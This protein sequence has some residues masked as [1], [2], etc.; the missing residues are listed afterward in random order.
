MGQ[1]SIF[2]RMSP[3]RAAYL[4]SR[5]FTVAPSTT[6]AQLPARVINTLYLPAVTSQGQLGVCGAY[7]I[8]YYYKTYQEAREHGWEHPNPSVDPEH[9]AS[10]AYTYKLLRH[11]PQAGANPLEVAQ[12]MVDFG[13]CDWQTMPY[14]DTISTVTWPEE[15]YW[16]AALPWRA[17]AAGLIEDLH[18]SQGLQTLKA[19]LAA[20]DLACIALDASPNLFGYPGKDYTSN[21]VLYALDAQPGDDFHAL[22]VIGYDDGRTYLNDITGEECHGAFLT[23]NSWGTNW[24]V[25]EPTMGTGGF[26]WIAYDLFKD[27]ANAIP[28]AYVMQ[29][30]TDYT[31]K[32]A[33]QLG[34]NNAESKLFG[35]LT[36]SGRGDHVVDLFPGLGMEARPTDQ[37]IWIDVS[38]LAA[39]G[40]AGFRLNIKDFSETVRGTFPVLR[41]ENWAGTHGIDS[42]FVP[43]ESPCFLQSTPQA[44]E[45]YCGRYQQALALSGATMREGDSAWGDADGDG[46]PDLVLTGWFGTTLGWRTLYFDNQGASGFVAGDKGLPAG[47]VARWVDADGDGDL[48]LLI[49]DDAGTSL[50]LNN[51]AAGFASSG[52]PLPGCDP[53]CLAVADFDNDG[54]ADLC[55]GNQEETVLYMNDGTGGFARL[56]VGLPTLR[57]PFSALRGSQIMAADLNGDHWT[58][59]VIAGIGEDATGAIYLNQGLPLRFTPSPTILPAVDMPAVAIADQDGDG[60]LDLAMGGC[61]GTRQMRIFCNDGNGVFTDQEDTILPNLHNGVICWT[62]LNGDGRPDLVATGRESDVYGAHDDY[63]YTNDSVA[64]T[65]TA[66]GTYEFFGPPLAKVS[67]GVAGIADADGDGNPDILVGGTLAEIFESDTTKMTAAVYLHGA[68]FPGWYAGNSFPAAPTSLSAAHDGHG[69]VTFTWNDASDAETT[70]AA[71]RYI[72]RCGTTSGGDEIR[73]G[74]VSLDNAGLFCQSGLSLGH[75]PMGTLHWQVRSID[76]AD[77]LSPWS[78]VQTFAVPGYTPQYQLRI[79]PPAN[80]YAGTTTPAPGVYTYLDGQSA[81]VTASPSPGFEFVAW[82]GDTSGVPDTGTVAVPMTGHRI[83]HPLFSPVPDPANPAWTRQSE[84]IATNAE[85]IE[86][87][88]ESFDGY[89]LRLGGRVG[90]TPRNLVY[91]STDGQSWQQLWEL[92]WNQGNTEFND[93]PWSGRYG[94]CSAVF[95]GKLWIMGGDTNDGLQSDV[96]SASDLFHWTQTTASAPWEARLEAGCAVFDGKLWILGGDSMSGYLDDVWATADGVTWTQVTSDAPWPPGPVQATVFKNQ[97]TVLS[98]GQVWQSANG[99]DWQLLTDSAPFGERVEASLEVYNGQLTVCGGRD[100]VWGAATNEVWSSDDGLTWTKTAPGEAAHWSAR[101]YPATCIHDGD[102]WLVGGRDDDGDAL[103]DVWSLGAEDLP[104]NLGRLRLSATPLDGGTLSPPASGAYIDGIGT[105]FELVATPADGY[106]FDHWDGPVAD[107]NS[108]ATTVTL[109]RDTIVTAHF[110]SSTEPLTMIMTPSGAGSV[111]PGTSVHTRGV[112]V[113]LLAT[114]AFGYV[115]DH[116]EGDA[117]GTSRT[118]QVLM[119]QARTTTAVFVVDPALPR[120]TICCSD[121]WATVLKRDGTVWAIGHNGQAQQGH[122]MPGYTDTFWP[123]AMASGVREAAIDEHGGIAV[124]AQGTLLGWGGYWRTTDNRLSSHAVYTYLPNGIRGLSGMRT[125]YFFDRYGALFDGLNRP[126]EV[127]YNGEG[128]ANVVSLAE[129]PDSAFAV[130]RNGELYAWGSNTCGQLGTGIDLASHQYPQLVLGIA[131]V[132]RIACGPEEMASFTLALCDDGSVW[133]WGDNTTGQLGRTGQADVPGAVPG[134]EQVV[135]VVAGAHYGMALDRNGDL[136]GWGSNNTGHFG[137]GDYED[138]PTPQR[139]ATGIAD[140]GAGP[141]YAVA[142]R[143]DGSFAWCGQVPGAASPLLAW[144]TIPGMVYDDPSIPLSVSVDPVEATGFYPAVGTHAIAPG[145]AVP[146]QAKDSTRYTFA[147]W[148]DVAADPLA[149]ETTL[150][151]TGP[152]TLAVRYG[153]A[154]DAMAK[155]TVGTS[156]GGSAS[157]AAG[158]WEY[159]PGT[160][161]TLRA[162]PDTSHRFRYWDGAVSDARSRDTTIVLDRDRTVLAHF[163]AIPLDIPPQVA[164]GRINAMEYDALVLHSDTHVQD[165]G[166]TTWGSTIR[167]NGESD[168]LDDVIRVAVGEKHLLALGR[169]GTVWGWDGNQYGQCGTGTTDPTDYTFPQKVQDG[170]GTLASIVGID[171]GADFSLALGNDGALFSWGRNQADQLGHSPGEDLVSVAMPVLD[172]DGEPLASI[173]SMACGDLFALAVTTD[174]TVLAWGDDSA[175]QLGPSGASRG[176][177]PVAVT[178]LPPILEVAAGGACA[179]ALTTNG[180]VWTW[181]AN[182]HGQLG[183][184]TMGASGAPAQVAGLPVVT[185]IA[186]GPE[187]MLALDGNGNVWAWGRGDLGALGNGSTSDSSTPVLVLAATGDDPLADIRSIDCQSVSYAFDASGALYQWGYDQSMFGDGSDIVSRPTH[188]GD[189]GTA[190][191]DATLCT[192]DLTCFPAGAGTISP[193]EGTLVVHR[194][195]LVEIRARAASG[196]RFIGWSGGVTGTLP[197]A[198]VKVQQN[199]RVVAN[200][201][202]DD[203]SLRLVSTSVIQGGKTRLELYFEGVTVPLEGL[204]AEIAAP[205]GLELGPCHHGQEVDANVEFLYSVPEPTRARLFLTD[206]DGVPSL[207]P[208]SDVPLASFDLSATSDCP[209]GIYELSLLA[210]TGQQTAGAYGNGQ[211]WLVPRAVSGT[212]E[213]MPPSRVSLLIVAAPLRADADVSESRPVSLD[214]CRDDLDYYLELW[215]QDQRSWGSPVAN[216]GVDLAL[217][218]MAVPQSTEATTLATAVTGAVSGQNVTGFGAALAED[219]IPPG[220]W[221]CVGRLRVRPQADGNGDVAVSNAWVE[222]GDSTMLSIP[223]IRLI[224]ASALPIAQIPNAAPVCAA[225]APQAAPW[226]SQISGTLRGTDANPDDVLSFSIVSGPTHGQLVFF[227]PDTGDFTYVAT[228]N[229]FGSDSF[230]YMAS[231]GTLASDVATQLLLVSEGWC[232][233]VSRGQDWCSF[234]QDSGATDSDTDALDMAAA[235][236]ASLAFAARGSATFLL[237][238]LRANSGTPVWRL[239]VAAKAEASNLSWDPLAVPDGL[240]LVQLLPVADEQVVID[241][242]SQSGLDLLPNTEYVFDIAMLETCNLSLQ[243]GWNLVSFPGSP[244]HRDIADLFPQAN[245]DNPTALQWG[246]GSYGTPGQLAPFQGYWVYSSETSSRGVAIVPAFD[247]AVQLRAGWNLI[248]VPYPTSMPDSSEIGSVIWTYRDFRYEAVSRLVPG[249]G[250]WVFSRS[251][252]AITFAEEDT[253]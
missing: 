87:T 110:V 148:S 71:M 35:T 89:L 223:A 185:A 78:P 143:T 215:I 66:R 253:P 248:G 191:P 109:A 181:G 43:V 4:K 127:G 42:P 162:D 101:R 95:D 17:R 164:T 219:A 75:V 6:R 55:L 27:T 85:T 24:G 227:D 146:L 228:A 252:L 165:Y 7:G 182:S 186:V 63:I 218:G 49:G 149:A 23:V 232:V 189:F 241:L 80:S 154:E 203:P 190:D 83:L 44:T 115:F 129:G 46:D 8:T 134:L 114:P 107:A 222:L 225:P 142:R 156:I 41:V 39:Y 221:G 171:A 151:A 120:G 210:Q 45:L 73:S 92:A 90:W 108:A 100:G 37:N 72:L 57:V 236:A 31:P 18:L 111:S 102:L 175:G 155:L 195:E 183:Q 231:D 212:V 130:T 32:L 233:A 117:S 250:Y 103:D 112:T 197:N 38:D 94:H 61:A 131:G 12:N 91:A 211:R 13:A 198:T 48:D 16:R 180:R 14:N 230:T 82:E 119:D 217:P 170:S 98:H 235:P 137:T 196:Y 60:D 9:C 126:V 161:V 206:P 193:Q 169:D 10:T 28:Q 234:G 15:Q 240:H 147:Y 81:S 238:D 237:R 214:S 26:C 86:H 30:R 25:E 216:V 178:G 158:E 179:A 77:A 157:P 58:D 104:A 68:A 199:M 96:W 213:V 188:R 204:Q 166:A 136:W 141:L 249:T 247:T 128:L 208:N 70:A 59:L 194:R 138:L 246:D 11:G 47:H 242:R 116:W 226:G 50:S 239:T 243:Q 1:Q 184:G 67:R 192:L 105:L 163:A 74:A 220:D 177:E 132:R 54:D 5:V 29:D 3:E 135:K 51:G 150:T 187:H 56:D 53:K 159:P 93:V 123:V 33:L 84:T 224:P 88:L 251:D 172:G 20:G 174:G 34:I 139:V 245:G 22:T 168:P 205:D 97:L 207:A 52:S 36:T 202:P 76:S 145:R 64:F 229:H 209:P 124:T 62:D 113:D 167:L 152:T 69:R 153:F 144:T 2:D 173:R 118:A 244:V 65:Q 79:E 160:V 133:S 201:A 21:D 176:S 125:H 19:H 121:T 200:F 40:R 99:A 106:A 122:D 140:V